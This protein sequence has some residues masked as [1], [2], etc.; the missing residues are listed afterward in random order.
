[1]PAWK[2]YA[3]QEHLECVQANQDLRNP[4][5]MSGVSEDELERLV[6]L[7]T[8]NAEKAKKA[9]ARRAMVLLRRKTMA[10]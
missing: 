5:I 3:L 1:M 9:R 10:T 8:G 6:L 7:A 4:D 2:V